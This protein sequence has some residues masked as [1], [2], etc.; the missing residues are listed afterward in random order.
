MSPITKTLPLGDVATFKSGGTPNKSKADYWGGQFPWISAKDLKFP[1]LTDSIDHLTKSGF[2]A[3]NIAPENSLLILVRGMTL[4]KDVPVCLAGRDV[5]FNQDIKALVVSEELIPQYLMF[6]LHSQKNRLLELVDSAG[7]GTGRLDTDLLKTFPV[8]V[9]P[10]PEQTAIAALFSNWSL[11]IEKVERLI[12]AKERQLKWLH[13]QIILAPAR[14]E[15][16]WRLFRICDIAERIQRKSDSG[17]FPILTIASASGFVL[18]E[19]KYSRFMAGKSLEDYTLLHRGEFAYNKGNSLRYQF[20]CVF[21]LQDYGKAL[22]P[23]VYVCFKLHED[24]D[25]NY[26]DHVFKADFLKAQLSA[27]VNTGIRN[28]GLLNISPAN[29]MKVTV[30][31]PPIDQQKQIAAILTTARQEIHLLKKQAEAYRRQ[32]RGL[33][34]KLLTGEWRVKLGGDEYGLGTD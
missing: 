29:F 19:E 7:H 5:A 3:A 1:V 14:L 6:Y 11:A 8:L 15:K 32:K 13:E 33:M 21:S 30:P 2:E 27:L 28:N 18:Q 25:A 10:L 9:P 22:V 31:L 26:L 24:V 12:A 23:H 20:G 4:F 34:Q 17:I 16:K